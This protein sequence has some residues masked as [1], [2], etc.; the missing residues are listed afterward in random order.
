MRLFVLGY[1]K[2]RVYNPLAKT[3]EDLR[4]NLTKEIENIPAQMLKNIFLNFQKRC[5]L[6]ITTGGGHIK[7][8]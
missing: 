4:S 2:Q 8:K 7:Y 3:F 5:Q 1:F 6:L